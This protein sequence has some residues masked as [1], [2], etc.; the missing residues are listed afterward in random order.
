MKNKESAYE[1]IAL[2]TPIIL[3]I[4][5]SLLHPSIHPYNPIIRFNGE[6]KDIIDHRPVS[7]GQY[8]LLGCVGYSNSSQL[9]FHLSLNLKVLPKLFPN[10]APL[11]LCSLLG[12]WGLVDVVSNIGRIMESS[13]TT[14]DNIPSLSS[15]RRE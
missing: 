8:F 5:L 11:H 10:D 13:C 3:P 12:G 4:F 9:T 6:K 7:S 1:Y 14:L 15:R 2:V